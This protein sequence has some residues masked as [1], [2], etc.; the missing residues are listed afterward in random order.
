MKTHV[1]WRPHGYP[2]ACRARARSRPA[3][4]AC[5]PCPPGPSGA[6]LGG[7]NEV[8]SAASD[9]G[10]IHM[11]SIRQPSIVAP[12]R[13]SFIPF[14][15]RTAQ[16]P[17]CHGIVRC[18]CARSGRTPC[19]SPRLSVQAASGCSPRSSKGQFVPARA[20]AGPRP[21]KHQQRFRAPHPHA[22]AA[23]CRPSCL[24]SCLMIG[25]CVVG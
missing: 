3:P 5:A 19:G 8:A 14:A 13:P 25:R 2:V 24:C 12:I 11:A 21:C 18:I 23:G 22:T 15:S 1:H 10:I 6:C 9:D 4:A 16:P 7:I 20:W 17:R